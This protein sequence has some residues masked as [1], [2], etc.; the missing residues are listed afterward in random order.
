MLIV[1]L[2]STH[3][4]EQVSYSKQG[5][6]VYK[7]KV[8]DVTQNLENSIDKWSYSIRKLKVLKRIQVIEIDDRNRY[9]SCSSVFLPTT[10]IVG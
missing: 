9:K 6:E 1:N 5:H 10:P 4:P 7:E 8:R 2:D 3:Q